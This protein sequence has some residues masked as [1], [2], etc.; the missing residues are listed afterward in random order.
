V[1]PV[2]LG[3]SGLSLSRRARSENRDS[4]WQCALPFIPFL[5]RKT[6]AYSLQAPREMRGGAIS[7][8]VWWEPVE[9]AFP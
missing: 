9:T 4:D 6:W 1:F 2:R 7:S 3:N 8:V 5:R